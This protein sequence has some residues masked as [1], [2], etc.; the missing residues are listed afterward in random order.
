M[1]VTKC[2]EA[3][4]SRAGER[5]APRPPAK[6]EPPQVVAAASP[7]PTEIMGETALAAAE[8][9]VHPSFSEGFSMAVLE[10]LACRLPVLL[11][12][13]CNFREA[14]KA[15]AAIEVSPDAQGAAA[16]LVELLSLSDRERKAMGERGRALVEAAYT[17][18]GVAQQMLNLYRW[19]CE[20]GERPDTLID[21]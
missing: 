21:P 18:D 10:A 4:M 20:G 16:G 1:R 6:S 8:L 19:L 11:T 14:A 5:R 15:G 17:W 2:P 9:F 12:P 3:T 7:S 13:E